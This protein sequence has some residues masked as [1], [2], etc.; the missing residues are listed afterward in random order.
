MPIPRFLAGL[1]AALALLPDSA[2]ATEAAAGRYIPG[3]FAFPMGA[4]IPPPGVYWSASTAYYHGSA[5]A[6]AAFP[7][8]GEIRAGLE[9]TIIGQTL[10]GLW[11]PDVEIAG[12]AFAIGLSLPVQ[13]LSATALLGGRE[14]RQSQ[15]ALGD[16]ALA[17]RIGWQSGPHFWSL[18]LNVFAPTG[19]WEKGVLDNIGMN[20]WTFSPNLSYTYLDAARGLDVSLNV[21][22]DIN[23]ENRDTDYRSGAMAHLDAL[24]LK[25]IGERFSAGLFASVL[26]QVQDDKGRIADRLDG[27]RGRSRAIGPVLTYTAG[28]K[29]RPVS[30]AFS[31]ASEFGTE[32][33]PRG[34]A[35]FL[36]ISGSF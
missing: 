28:P 16:I 6:D 27:F 33:R 35:L 4:A 31:W 12:G 3:L 11:V 21:G 7:V 18:G 20:Y 30:V 13:Y 34:N 23:T 29:E 14:E 22:I 26:E 10:T 15:T 8:G 25:R 19:A 17:P 5:G 32:N 36:T 1:A 2:G 24:V 9:A